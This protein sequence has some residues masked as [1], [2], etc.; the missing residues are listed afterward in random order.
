MWN[1]N[2]PSRIRVFVIE[3]ALGPWP[4]DTVRLSA[5]PGCNFSPSS[6]KAWSLS[7]DFGT[8]ALQL[9]TSVAACRRNPDVRADMLCTD[10]HK[11]CR[12][13]TR[14]RFF[15]S[16]TCN[17]HINL[18]CGLCSLRRASGI[19]RLHDGRSSSQP[20]QLRKVAFSFWLR[21][22]LSLSAVHRIMRNHVPRFLNLSRE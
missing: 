8:R 11:R 5:C 4:S 6:N 21:Q 17:F 18:R 1:I 12:S 20:E 10:K 22:S 7:P 16:C 2:M 15:S 19:T 14:I 3:S 9:P 13:R